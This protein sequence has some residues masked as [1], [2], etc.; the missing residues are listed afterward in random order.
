MPEFHS[1]LI[2]VNA[3][4]KPTFPILDN[5]MH[6]DPRGLGAENAKKFHKAGGTHL[7]VVYKP[8]AEN[9]LIETRSFEKRFELTISLASSCEEVCPEV[10]TFVVLGPYPVDLIRMMDHMS[11][12]QAKDIMFKGMD[13]ARKYVEEGLAIAIGEIGRPHFP[14][15]QEIMDCSNEILKYGM[16]CAKDA[17]CPV[18]L[19]TE[20]ATD[21]VWQD[22]AVMADSV[23][24]NREMVIK[25]FSPPVVNEAEN[26][27]LF[28]SV[29]ASKHNVKDA[30]RISD[31]FMMETDYLDDPKRPGAVLGIT[32]VPK[33]T[34]LLLSQE[35]ATEEQLIKIHKDHPERLYGISIDL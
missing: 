8:Y 5:H 2:E 15:E 24:L 26:C 23:G 27:G 29:L 13:M 33:V 4:K 28:P 35:L 16:A 21:D 19:H 32:T 1:R 10:K 17:G 14:V 9:S 6:L 34:K 20:S 3:I 25:H 18:V 22:L 12:E 31:R 7:V 30:I 11:M